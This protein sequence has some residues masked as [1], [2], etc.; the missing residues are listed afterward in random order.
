M[1]SISS[2]QSNLNTRVQKQTNKQTQVLSVKIL[3]IVLPPLYIFVYVCLYMCVVVTISFI[4]LFHFSI[5]S[6]KVSIY[7]FSLLLGCLVAPLFRFYSHMNIWEY[8][9]RSK[10]RIKSTDTGHTTEPENGS[11]FKFG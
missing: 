10:G 4:F 11:E 7:K 3:T 9:F 6:E 5:I 2:I 1:V 8:C